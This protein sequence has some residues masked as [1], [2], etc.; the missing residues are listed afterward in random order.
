MARF[1]ISYDLYGKDR[2]DDFHAI[3]DELRDLGAIPIQYSV[4]YYEGNLS[5]EEIEQALTPPMNAG[6]TWVATPSFDLDGR[7]SFPNVGAST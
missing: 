3:E 2:D 7:G 4:W 6:S 5:A 1:I